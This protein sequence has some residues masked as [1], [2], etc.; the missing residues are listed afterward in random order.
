M[1]HGTSSIGSNFSTSLSSDL[2]LHILFW[3]VLLL[4]AL[5]F[6]N[7][8]VLRK[9]FILQRVCISVQCEGTDFTVTKTSKWEKYSSVVISVRIL[10]RPPK[11][12]D[13]VLNWSCMNTAQALLVFQALLSRLGKAIPPGCPFR[14]ILCWTHFSY[15]SHHDNRCSVALCTPRWH[16]N[17]MLV[18][19]SDHISCPTIVD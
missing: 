7:V 17:I 16:N 1:V 5:A 6:P 15:S 10:D 18:L 14:V 2:T 4:H 13:N 19:E 11:I 12:S 3:F 9:N 8:M